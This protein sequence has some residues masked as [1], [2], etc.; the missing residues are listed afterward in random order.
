MFG[1]GDLVETEGKEIVDEGLVVPRVLEHD[2]EIDIAVEDDQ[3]RALE[4][5]N[6]KGRR[7]R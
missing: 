4:R 2:I 3:E 7:G 6:I 5:S 1:E